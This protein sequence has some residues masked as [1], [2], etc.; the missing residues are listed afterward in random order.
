ML[1]TVIKC[2]G[3][4][5]IRQPSRPCDDFLQS[6]TARSFELLSPSGAADS[7]TQA[8]LRTIADRGPTYAEDNVGL[9]QQRPSPW[10]LGR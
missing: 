10:G 2:K 3:R 9:K 6:L 5:L 4:N 8:A 1:W 7:S